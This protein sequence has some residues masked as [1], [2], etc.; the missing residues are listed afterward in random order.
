MKKF[1]SEKEPSP[2]CQL[3]N[4]LLKTCD[5]NVV[6]IETSNGLDRSFQFHLQDLSVRE[7]PIPKGITKSDERRIKD[8]NK[9]L[10]TRY[11]KVVNA[12]EQPL[13]LESERFE[14]ALDLFKRLQKCISTDNGKL[15]KA[16]YSEELLALIYLGYFPQRKRNKKNSVSS[17]RVAV[18]Y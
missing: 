13:Q 4:I 16:K 5:K 9:R 2:A 17:F 18:N 3:C 14:A 1:S 8:A 6:T 15:S 10:R 12:I 11:G 7:T